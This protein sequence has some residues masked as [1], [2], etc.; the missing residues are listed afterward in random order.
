M[1]RRTFVG[2]GIAAAAA[3]AA[4]RARLFAQAAQAG[5]PGSVVE[6]TLGRVRGLVIGGVN[7]FKG[8]PY[9]ASTTGARRFQPPA[10]AAAWT[11]VR[12]TFSLGHRSPQG[13]AGFVPEWQ[14]LTGT[15][16]AGEDCLDL[17]VWTPQATRTAARPVM[18]WLHGGGYTGGSPARHSV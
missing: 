4:E 3:A 12:E 11:G 18:V 7:A 8:V 2:I 1:N 5:A 6:T 10:K 15:E 16:A 13:R 14:P 9:G 17:N